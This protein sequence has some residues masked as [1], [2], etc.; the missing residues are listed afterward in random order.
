MRAGH[1]AMVSKVIDERHVLLNHANWS[2]PA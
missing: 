2:R 1:V